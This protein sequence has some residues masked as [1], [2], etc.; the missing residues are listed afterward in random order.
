MK[1]DD[2]PIK[3]YLAKAEALCTLEAKLGATMDNKHLGIG[4]PPMRMGCIYIDSIFY[5]WYYIAAEAIHVIGHSAQYYP[6]LS[7]DVRKFM[8]TLDL[9]KEVDNKDYILRVVQNKDI[10]I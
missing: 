5:P 9:V 7:K 3:E 4:Y 1:Y 10:K 6:S 8:S 2:I